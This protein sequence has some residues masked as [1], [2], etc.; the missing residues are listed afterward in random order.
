MIDRRTFLLGLA[1]TGAIGA[2][3]GGTL[4]STDGPLRS[5]IARVVRDHLAEGGMTGTD[6][7]VFARDYLASRAGSPM[8]RA[9]A[10]GEG[11]L[12]RHMPLDKARVR[13]IDNIRRSIVTEYLVNSDMFASRRPPGATVTYAGSSARICGTA[14]PFAQFL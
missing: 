9:Y 7:D 2:V 10:A 3:A 5:W 14:N 8:L 6:L 13:E 12:G 4:L 11:L 1:G